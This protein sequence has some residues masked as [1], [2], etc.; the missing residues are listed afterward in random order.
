MDRN[1]SQIKI[2]LK[3]FVNNFWLVVSNKTALLLIL[4]RSLLKYPF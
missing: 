2:K 1:I 3:I 4:L